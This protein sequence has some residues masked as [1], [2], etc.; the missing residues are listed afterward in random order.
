[1]AD[2][3]SAERL[4]EML[5]FDAARKGN[6]SQEVLGEALKEIQEERAKEGKVKAKEQL[7]KAMQ[8]REQMDK[9]SKEFNKQQQKMDKELCKIL[10]QIE[11]NLR[12]QAVCDE[13][14]EKD[15]EC[16]NKG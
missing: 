10:S 16:T 5:G 9:A 1:M 2:K 6:L 8:I 3:N 4:Q 13:E 14:E 12:G 11:G 7:V 15:K